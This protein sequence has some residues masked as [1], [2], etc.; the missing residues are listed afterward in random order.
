MVVSSSFG[1][2][3]EDGSDAV[4]H[5]AAGIAAFVFEGNRGC[6]GQQGRVAFTKGN[7]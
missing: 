5:G 6:D 2:G 4:E 3:E 1:G 7:W